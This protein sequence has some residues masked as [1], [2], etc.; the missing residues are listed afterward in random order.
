M[1][2]DQKVAQ[3]DHGG[4]VFISFVHE[5]EAVARAL[6]SYVADGLKLSK[7]FLS[8]EQSLVYAGE[9]WIDRIT[10]ALR[11]AK[12]V[13]LLLSR[14]SVSRPWVNFEAGGAWLSDKVIV[15]VC[16]GNLTPEVLPKPYSTLQ[17]LRIP[18]ERHYL[19]TSLHHHLKSTVELP[20][21]PVQQ[22]VVDMLGEGE[23]HLAVRLAKK[24]TH[25]GY[26]LDEACGKFIDE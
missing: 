13:V 5:D 20:L 1:I 2:H 24:L 16:V 25:P 10:A 6:Q 3:P 23:T 18:E 17:A 8:S 12:V 21:G 7:V 14:R 9:R 22:A 11:D 26:L 15:P 4:E 19:L